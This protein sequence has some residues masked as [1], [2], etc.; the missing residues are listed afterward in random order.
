MAVM[1]GVGGMMSGRPSGFEP[2]DGV[3]GE[4]VE[5]GGGLGAS[6]DIVRE[7]TNGEGG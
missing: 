2:F 7:E 1:E 5:D 6:A 3:A 4:V